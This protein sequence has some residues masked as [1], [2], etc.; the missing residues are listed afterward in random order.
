[1]RASNIG[2]APRLLLHV[3]IKA[4][5]SKLRAFAESVLFTKRLRYL[6]KRQV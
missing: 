5:S 1:M 6:I 3:S 2:S 4:R